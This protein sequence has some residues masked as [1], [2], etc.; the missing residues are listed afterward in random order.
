MG[1]AG[2]WCKYNLGAF[3]GAKASD[4][5]GDYYAWGEMET[6]DN[7]SWETYKHCDGTKETIAKYNETDGLKQLKP[8]DDVV[9]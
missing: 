9:T 7:Y 8:V 2:I 6:K 1:K 5:Y 3:P 4:W